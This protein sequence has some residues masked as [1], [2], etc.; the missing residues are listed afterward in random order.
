[1]IPSNQRQLVQSTWRIAKR[2]ADG[3]TRLFYG[4]LFEAA[5]AVRGL[6]PDDMDDQR[7]K[8]AAV[9]DA[10]VVGLSNLNTIMTDLHA[11][12]ERHVAYGAE[13]EHYPVVGETLLWALDKHLGEQFT[14][15]AREAWS[16]TIDVLASVMIH[17]QECAV[18]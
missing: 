8:L 15:E 10:A 2:D 6:F 12:G 1:M 13:P 4:R 18:G 11:L 3:L 17:A 9:L 5:P 14:P 7:A 16:S